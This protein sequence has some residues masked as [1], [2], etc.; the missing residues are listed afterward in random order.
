ML[1][2]FNESDAFALLQLQE[3]VEF[4]VNFDMAWQW[5]DYTRKDNAK[6]SF[7]NQGFEEGFDFSSFN[8]K[9]TG[10][11]PSES[12]NL[13][14][15]CFKMWGMGTRTDIGLKIKRYFVECEKRLK[16]Q[17][18]TT[19]APRHPNEAVKSV[20]DA[21]DQV[22]QKIAVFDPRLAQVLI[23]HAMRGID[24]VAMLPPSQPKM[25][26]FVEIATKLGFKVGKEES[27]L[28]KFVAPR[29]RKA[30]GTEPEECERECGGGFRNIKLYPMDDPIVIAAIEDYFA[31]SKK[32]KQA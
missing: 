19:L 22:R 30:Y 28:G 11:R 2:E 8:R 18:K 5:L 7:L 3:T 23:D 9:S 16:A 15:D 12:Y 31:R 25:G 29:W 32:L 6:E 20:T 27:G 13:T 14:I 4:P 17:N 24:S 10:G 1:P 26:G 21:I